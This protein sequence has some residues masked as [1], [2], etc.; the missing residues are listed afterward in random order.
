VTDFEKH[1]PLSRARYNQMQGK[2]DTSA[3]ADDEAGM[4]LVA[5]RLD[6]QLK[7]EEFLVRFREAEHAWVRVW[8]PI[9]LAVAVSA[10]VSLLTVLANRK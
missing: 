4:R 1:E 7:L 3:A 2:L 6:A 9:F 5:V 8:A 10:I